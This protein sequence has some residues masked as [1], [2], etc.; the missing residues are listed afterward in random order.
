MTDDTTVMTEDVVLAGVD[1]VKDFDA[2]TSL[3]GGASG[4]VRAVDGVSLELHRGK[5]LGLVGESGS[6][7]STVGRMLLRLLDTSAG[8]II[9]KGDDITDVSRGKLRKLR[10][11]M[12]LVF[13]DPYSSLNPTMRIGD[14]IG[15]PIKYHRSFS[16]EERA[17]EVDWILVSV[18][19][20]ADHAR[21]FPDELS[22]G[23]RQRVAIARALA[24]GPEILICDEAVSAL[25]ISIQSQILNLLLR[26]Q[27][28]IGLSMLFISHDLS[29]VRHVSHEIAVMYLGHVVEHGP[30]SRVADD[31]A[32]PYTQALLS[33]VPQ[34]KPSS[35]R[36]REKILLQGDPP[37][38][39]NR[40]KGCP[41]VNRCPFAF[42]PCHEVRPKHTPLIDGGMVACHLQTDGPVLAGRTLKGLT[43]MEAVGSTPRM[44]D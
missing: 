5:T 38:P 11:A 4:K 40:P 19:L 30:A 22:G 17:D 41:F 26:L 10:K 43:P 37:S 8:S 9:L 7:K 15:E 31:P 24:S 39:S 6:G 16:A 29:V 34:A 20:S 25:D 14:I 3:F 21:R 2:R 12:Q 44:A 23:Q 13:Q 32:H 18:G 36:D 28:D 27:A 42:E 35:R 33:A 1:L